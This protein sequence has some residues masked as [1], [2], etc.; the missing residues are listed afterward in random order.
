MATIPTETGVLVIG[1][2]PAGLAAAIAARQKGLPALVVD[3]DRPP[4]DKACGEGLLPAGVAALQRLGVSLSASR[5]APFRGIR[6]L[7]NKSRVRA[8]FPAGP[9]L[10]IQRTE[11]HRSLVRAA[12]AA[13]VALCWS[14]RLD[15]LSPEGAY[16]AGRLVRARWIIGADGQSSLVRR[17]ANLDAC[18]KNTRRFG[19]RR[20]YRV[21]RWTDYTEVYWGNRFQLFVTPIG[22]DE[23][24]VVVLSRDARLRIEHA[25]EH[26]PELARRLSG[27]VATSTGRGAV[28]ASC[29]LKSVQR[30]RFALVGDASGSV[31]ALAGAGLSLA[32]QQA[33]ALAEALAS[34]D[35]RRYQAAH[36]RLM[37]RPLWMAELMLAACRNE[38]VR[39]HLLRM[40]AACPSVFS[41]LM[42]IHAGTEHGFAAGPRAGGV[43]SEMAAG[44]PQRILIT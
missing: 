27:A 6:F 39:S 7:D 11:L 4:L 26:L 35:L 33:I 19:Y 31:D 29:R 10:G 41:W 15:G 23:V 43:P 14:A 12:E 18:W 36:R 38:S 20:R 37:M 30:G 28:T 25:L 2:G 3:Q 13:D 32:F 21:A 24:C 44:L 40:L 8:D 42:R 17:W 16:V 22:A 9:A 1:G 5:A 34:G